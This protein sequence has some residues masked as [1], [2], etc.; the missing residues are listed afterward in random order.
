MLKTVFAILLAS[1]AAGCATSTKLGDDD[2]SAAV[3]ER[4]K[5]LAGH[6][7][8]VI[9]ETGG[10]YT[11]GSTPLDLT[12]TPDGTWSGTIGKAPAL[13]TARF[14]GRDLV[15]RGPHTRPRATT[16]PCTCG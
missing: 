3:T 5:P 16:S 14:K 1:L 4:L 13:G 10:W 6:W 9:G 8:G 11:Q 2:V 12:I 15:L 7:Q